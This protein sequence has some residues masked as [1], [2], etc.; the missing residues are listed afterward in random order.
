VIIH[1]KFMGIFLIEAV[2]KQNLRRETV[3]SDDSENGPDYEPEQPPEHGEFVP[4]NWE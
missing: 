4:A 1:V 3:G 2:Q